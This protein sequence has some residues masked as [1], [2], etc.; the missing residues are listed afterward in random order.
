[1]GGFISQDKLWFGGGQLSFY[2]YA[3]G[4]PQ[5]Y[6]DPT[7][8]AGG[9]I[10]GA[11]VPS[12]FSWRR[13]PGACGSYGQGVGG[14]NLP[15]SND[16]EDP[17]KTPGAWSTHRDSEYTQYC[18]QVYCRNDQQECHANGTDFYQMSFIGGTVSKYPTVAQLS[19]FNPNCKCTA[20]RTLDQIVASSPPSADGDDAGE[21]V[22][23]VAE[24]RQRAAEQRAAEANVEP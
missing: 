15:N 4:D 11:R 8:S 20:T 22:T 17:P 2:G 24:A 19:I 5:D 1:M 6:T 23:K 7:G 3:F 13:A 14:S 10:S 18:V 12:S 9:P 16:P 21:L